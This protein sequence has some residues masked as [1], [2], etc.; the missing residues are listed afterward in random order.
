MSSEMTRD[1][2]SN[3][4]GTGAGGIELSPASTEVVTIGNGIF[5]PDGT[6]TEPAI[7]FQD[8]ANCG[9]YSPGNDQISLTAHGENAFVV[10]G[11]A[12][13]VN[14]LEVSPSTTGNDLTIS[15]TGSDTN[16]SIN[17][18][19]KGTGVLKVGGTTVSLA[20]HTHDDRYYTETEVDTLLSG[21]SDTTHNHDGTYAA[22]SHTHSA[23]DITSGTFDNARI[24]QGNVTQHQA[25]LSLTKSQI[26]DFGTYLTSSSSIKDLGDVYDSM[27]PANQDVLM[28]DNTNS[29]WTNS[30]IIAQMYT[31][32]EAALIAIN[33]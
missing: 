6:K 11:V 29:R 30:N 22:L 17:M 2:S 21:K 24:S 16:V 7:R 28:W 19:P 25:A 18:V 13:S 26:T 4:I 9:I 10:T 27:T 23:S 5:L 33:G 1:L 15:A 14:T 32:I 20:G 12:S 3:K 31:D 8:D